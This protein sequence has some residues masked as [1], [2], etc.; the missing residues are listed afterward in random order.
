MVKLDIYYIEN[1]SVMLDLD[2]IFRTAW[3]MVGRKGY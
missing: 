3:A 2:I 1:W